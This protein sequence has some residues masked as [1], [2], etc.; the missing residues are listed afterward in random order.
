[1]STTIKGYAISIL[2]FMII[3]GTVFFEL[4]SSTARVFGTNGWI[5]L[6]VYTILI[7]TQMWLLYIGM[8]KHK[9]LSIF[10][11]IQ[12]YMPSW[13]GKSIL[14][15]LTLLFVCVAFR[16]AYSIIL[17]LQFMSD[18]TL[19]VRYV[20]IILLI[21]AALLSLHG[22]YTVTKSTVLF[23]TL[24]IWISLFGLIQFTDFHMTRL[25][26]FI[27][28]GGSWNFN[29]MLDIYSAFQG[30]L[31]ILYI[32]PFID[33]NLKWFKFT[34]IAIAATGIYFILYCLLTQGLV[35]Y[36]MLQTINHVA[37]RTNGASRVTAL[38]YITDLLFITFVF[39]SVITSAVYLW[40]AFQSASHISKQKKQK[41]QNYLKFVIIFA[42]LGMVF[43]PV[44]Y[45][46]WNSFFRLLTLIS[47]ILG[48]VFTMLYLLIPP[49]KAKPS[50]SNNLTSTDQDASNLGTLPVMEG[51]QPSV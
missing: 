35:P 15:L 26:P 44:S 41:K 20:T 25:T 33:K 51:E 8:V 22:I 47:L 24:T 21:V 39:S 49:N 34:A 50:D 1:M 32:T 40:A 9:N 7:I 16:I 14:F 38:V 17:V 42:A 48:I 6:L 23:F 2:L 19:K 10:Q 37:L 36:E 12:T 46:Q 28:Q 5:M 18:P 43:I 3:R 4:P 30:Y 29:E 31:V 13:L 27:F 45:D 11:F